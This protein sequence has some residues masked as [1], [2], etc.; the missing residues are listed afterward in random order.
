[1]IV[2]HD[3]QIVRHVTIAHISVQYDCIFPLVFI[4]GLDSQF[5]TIILKILIVWNFKKQYSVRMKF[6]L[7]VTD[8]VTSMESVLSSI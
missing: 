8:C 1:M 4:N 6:I 7:N 3:D 2:T 5:Q